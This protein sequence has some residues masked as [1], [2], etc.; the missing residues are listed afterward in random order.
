VSKTLI[1]AIQ[2]I[3]CALVL[4]VASFASAAEVQV[5]RE[6][7][8]A[9]SASVR[10]AIREQCKLRTSIPEAIASNASEAELVDG[11]GNL[12]LEITQVHG[13]GGW[14]FSGPKWVEVTGKLS[15][16]GKTYSFRAKRYS[17]FNP[18]GGVC[19]ILTKCGRAIGSDIATWLQNPTA[20]AELG[21][22]R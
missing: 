13:P 18:F 19:S 14:I 3:A 5:P 1:T 8:F 6:I 11:N 2:S 7:D 9:E 22:A 12:S 15:R 4:G 17:A 20:D 16:E 10:S 21:D